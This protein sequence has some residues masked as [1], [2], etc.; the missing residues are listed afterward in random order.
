MAAEGGHVK[1]V[2]LLLQT[3]A[4]AADENLEGMTTLHLA[5]KEGHIRV[6][7]AL[8]GAL[9]WKSC[10]RKNGLTAL[11]VASSC[12]Q[13]ECV[14]ELLT[15]IPAGIRSER[16]LTDP[17]ADV[18]TNDN[19]VYWSFRLKINSGFLGSSV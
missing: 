3:G 9:D 4:K 5:S 6:I 16:P 1:V 10:S 17:N 19:C 8:K 12:G 13:M 14:S 2:R 7:Q 18:S 11:H 15:Q